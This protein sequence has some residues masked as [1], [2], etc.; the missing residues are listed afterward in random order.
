MHK[1]PLF[2]PRIVL[3]AGML[4]DRR[5]IIVEDAISIDVESKKWLLNP[6]SI[7]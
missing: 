3:R 1:S 7:Y 6:N 4:Q 2:Y 5:T